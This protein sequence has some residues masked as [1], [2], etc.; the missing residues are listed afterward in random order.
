MAAGQTVPTPVSPVTPA[1]SPGMGTSDVA[2]SRATLSA[3]FPFPV[4]L[5][6]SFL[7]LLLLLRDPPPRRPTTA[8]P[9]SR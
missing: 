1:A 3:G 7:K 8:A 6:W 9:S 4:S 2:A 5:P